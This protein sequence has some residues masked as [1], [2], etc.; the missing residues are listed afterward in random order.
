MNSLR[1]LLT[2]KLLLGGELQ[3][4]ITWVS[5][6]CIELIIHKHRST[7]EDNQLYK[8]TYL[9]YPAVFRGRKRGNRVMERTGTRF[10]NRKI[11]YNL[12]IDVHVLGNPCYFHIF[13]QEWGT[14]MILMGKIDLRKNRIYS[15]CYVKS[16]LTK[17]RCQTACH[18]SIKILSKYFYIFVGNV[19]ISLPSSRNR[20]TWSH[21]HVFC[22]NRCDMHKMI[23][24]SSI[25]NYLCYGTVVMFQIMAAGLHT[26]SSIR[27]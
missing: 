24:L 20:W 3:A 25:V 15:V 19:V 7:R 4:P 14:I 16:Q 8:P 9:C 2:H 13:F 18:N 17:I 1:F 6:T 21:W 22:S 10:E 5:C 26:H 23:I 12:S 27:L 11:K